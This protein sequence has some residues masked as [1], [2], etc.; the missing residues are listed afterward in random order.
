V[1][2]PVADPGI[3]VIQPRDGLHVFLAYGPTTP[4][5]SPSSRLLTYRRPERSNNVAVEQADGFGR[6]GDHG[7]RH[8][9]GLRGELE[10]LAAALVAWRR[11]EGRSG[12]AG[13]PQQRADRTVRIRGGP[14][15]G[16]RSATMLGS[17]AP[18]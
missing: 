4:M 7:D 2:A 9:R 8:D 18:V 12:R 13:R 3:T 5:N 14:R 10:D 6:S 11:P 15:V 17:L 1:D 16:G